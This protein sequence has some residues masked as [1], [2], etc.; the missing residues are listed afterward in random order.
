[1]SDLPVYSTDP[2]GEIQQSKWIHTNE[3]G[4]LS[5]NNKNIIYLFRKDE[6]CIHGILK[7]ARFPIY[8]IKSAIQ[9]ESQNERKREGASK[10]TDKTTSTVSSWLPPVPLAVYLEI[11]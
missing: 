3:S 11:T 1:M 9:R 7:C 4:F 6:L 10:Q 5:S 2:V 8:R